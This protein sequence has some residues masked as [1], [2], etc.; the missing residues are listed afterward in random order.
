[1]YGGY[2]SGSQRG[3]QGDADFTTAPAP[4]APAP[5]Q[6]FQPFGMGGYQAKVGDATWAGMPPSQGGISA[7]TRGPV[8]PVGSQIMNSP[9]TPYGNDGMVLGTPAGPSM[10]E[11]TPPP[12]ISQSSG[13]AMSSLMG[14]VLPP[15]PPPPPPAPISALTSPSYAGPVMNSPQSP[16][17]SPTVFRGGPQRGMG[18]ISAQEQ[19]GIPRPLP[20]FAPP[21]NQS[22]FPLREVSDSLVDPREGGGF[23]QRPQDDPNGRYSLQ[24]ALLQQRLRQRTRAR[25]RYPLLRD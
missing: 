19:R 13:N 5:T 24:N 6:P 1:M 2:G 3:Y 4:P 9:S 12:P 21:P 15:P 18:V 22:Q 14:P 20:N 16:R 8:G 25:S 10:M 17:A 23:G 11:A 7:L